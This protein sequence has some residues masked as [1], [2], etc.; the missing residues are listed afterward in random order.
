MIDINNLEPFGIWSIKEIGIIGRPINGPTKVI[1]QEDIL[2]IRKFRNNDVWHWP[3]LIACEEWSS[4]KDVADL[5]HAMVI[6]MS[7]LEKPV[8]LKDQMET[9]HL[10]T[11]S[12]MVDIIDSK[13][14]KDAA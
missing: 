3:I 11:V 6:K 10:T 5:L 4:L 9:I 12:A 8:H 14:S 13:T 7:E 1:L 2:L